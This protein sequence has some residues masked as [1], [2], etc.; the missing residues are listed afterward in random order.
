MRTIFKNVW[1]VTVNRH[2]DVIKNGVVVVDNDRIAYVG[3]RL[4]Q[5]VSG[6]R[7]I[8]GKGKKMLMP[9]FVDGHTHLPM[10]LF[11]GGADDMELHS[12]LNDRIFPLESRLTNQTVYD[13][14]LLALCEM[15]RAGIT[16]VNDMYTVNRA[17]MP[18]LEKLP[19]R[20]TLSV[21]LFGQADNADEQL[22]DNISF[23]REYNGAMDG[24]IRIGLGPHAEYTATPA[25]LERCADAARQLHCP[26]HIHVSE[27]R[28]EHV[29][30]VQ[31]HGVT[32]VGL[33]NKVGFF[34][35]NTA[36]MAHCVWLDDDDIELVAQKGAAVLHNP[37][38]NMKLGS[39]FARV[40]Y[41][42]QKGVKIALAT[43]GAASNNALDM[44]EEMRMCALMHKGNTLDATA[45]RARQGLY[46][47]TRGAAIALGY[48]D[49]GSV[50]QGYKADLCLVD[51][52]R[53]YYQPMTDL[54][55]HIVYGGSSRDVV[56]TMVNGRVLYEQGQPMGVDLDALYARVQT[57]YDNI[58]NV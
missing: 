20:A 47:A 43:D 33:L 5:D 10:V 6:A 21:G 52:D 51:I 44:W 15:L 12:W 25:F 16:T 7:I 26:L 14:T 32:P 31:R 4:P 58:F 27:T 46:M 41:M 24:L 39:G 19:M 17:M 34:D 49:V 28:K 45:V 3:D 23:H 29:Q 37:C 38:S 36:L 54:I 56:M 55:H 2:C 9:G 13:G 35:E 30:C 1:V 53:P 40:P 57:H 8:D 48:E 18:A 22:R 11:R 42:L 50:A